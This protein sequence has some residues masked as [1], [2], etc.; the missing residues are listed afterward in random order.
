MIEV[1]K[2]LKD[3][4]SKLTLFNVWVLNYKSN[5]KSWVISEFYP[6]FFKG[7]IL[8]SSLLK[9]NWQCLKYEG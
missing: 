5:E 9:F 6:L 1:G 2:N 4:Y 8:C 3:K 7:T